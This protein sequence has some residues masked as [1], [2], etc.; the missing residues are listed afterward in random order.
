MVPDWSKE[1]RCFAGMLSRERDAVSDLII[2]PVTEVSFTRGN[3][4][5][6]NNNNK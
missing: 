6:N 4:N 3:N 2:D 1:R 5:N